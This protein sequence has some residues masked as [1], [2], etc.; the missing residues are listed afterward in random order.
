MVLAAGVLGWA[1]ENAAPEFYSEISN[2]ATGL[3]K[4]YGQR[5]INIK[6][7]ILIHMK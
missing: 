4:H 7:A 6:E 1:T 2:L 3:C 5:D